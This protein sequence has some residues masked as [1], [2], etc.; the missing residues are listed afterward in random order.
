MVLVKVNFY[1][2]KKYLLPKIR[3]N[4]EFSHTTVFKNRKAGGK[5]VLLS[6]HRRSV[7]LHS[8][9]R[10]IWESG[11][12][13]L[14]RTLRLGNGRFFTIRASDLGFGAPDW[15]IARIGDRRVTG[16][17]L[18][19]CRRMFFLL[20]PGITGRPAYIVHT[21]FRVGYSTVTN[22]DLY[23]SRILRLCHRMFF[24]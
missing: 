13:F 2:L 24:Y 21:L 17:I 3:R 16:R 19:L 9:I 11:P 12:R 5:R 14:Y 7:T 10:A 22:D 18:R 23:L 4:R 6:A 15:C 20:V 1:F 8:P